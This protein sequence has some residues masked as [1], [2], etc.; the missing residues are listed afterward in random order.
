MPKPQKA[1][2]T[3]AELLAKHP[4]PPKNDW[5]NG[6]RGEDA[7]RGYDDDGFPKYDPADFKSDQEE[8]EEGGSG[9][10]GAFA[11]L[12]SLSGGGAEDD[13]WIQVTSKPKKKA[14]APAAGP[15]PAAPRRPTAPA[16]TTVRHVGP[17]P[18]V[19][20]P[21][22]GG[23]EGI[24]QGP[25]AGPSR[26]PYSVA[27]ITPVA[28]RPARS[29]THDSEGRP[30]SDT[31]YQTFQKVHRDT[32]GN[33][34][35]R[36]HKTDVVTIRPNGDVVLTSGGYRTRTTFLSV[37]EA[38]Q[39]LGLTV[40][41]SQGG[42][43]RVEWSVGGPDGSRTPWE[44]GMVV[45]AT[46]EADRGRGQRL[47]AA[48]NVGTPSVS[49]GTATRVP[50]PATI[51]AVP[52]AAA[53]RAPLLLPAQAPISTSTWS[54]RSA[55]GIGTAPAYVPHVRPPTATAAAAPLAAGPIPVP[56]PVPTART[57]ESISELQQV[58]NAA[59]AI[60]N[61]TSVTTRS[62]G[63][64]PDILRA[65]GSGADLDDEHACIAC[66]AAL[67]TTL[68]IPCGHMVMCG[69]CAAQVLERS[70][71]CPMCREQVISHVTVT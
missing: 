43:G 6:R 42:E 62:G 37:Q 40:H 59:L 21:R 18:A 16:P 1:K 34:C 57:A 12:A 13:D 63:N 54:Y 55:A 56:V 39:P 47:L 48:Y 30:I 14:S 3:L 35:M 29:Q 15:I 31:Y 5:S 22:T 53:A 71:V 68:L 26:A 69:P 28:P 58:L 45:P 38:L 50:A 19:S 60:K 17:I 11:I 32:S 46:G 25:A 23:A 36:F 33:V 9:A 27:Q 20:S 7:N 2:T 41:S 65:S 70:G 64:I 10:G 44:D 8:E 24:V 67:K 66:M 61:E 51:P 4:E 49:A 52:P